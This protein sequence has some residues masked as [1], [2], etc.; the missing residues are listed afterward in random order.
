[1][2][3]GRNKILKSYRYSIDLKLGISGHIYICL[4][5]LFYCFEMYNPPL[6]PWPLFFEHTVNIYINLLNNNQSIRINKNEQTIKINQKIKI[7]NNFD[8]VI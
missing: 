7:I 8:L 3:Y 2:Y 6:N 4:Y 5:E 1:M